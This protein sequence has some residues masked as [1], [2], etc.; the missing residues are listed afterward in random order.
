M[1]L[2]S[3][4]E[5]LRTIISRRH[6]LSFSNSALILLAVISLTATTAGFLFKATLPVLNATVSLSGLGTPD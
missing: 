6:K 4:L 3:P 5:G 1:K 2:P